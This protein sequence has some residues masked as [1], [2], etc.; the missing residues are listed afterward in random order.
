M[1]SRLISELQEMIQSLKFNVETPPIDLAN[2]V[3][4]IA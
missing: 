1:C 2:V 3:D 4:S